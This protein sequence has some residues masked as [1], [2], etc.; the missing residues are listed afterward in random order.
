MTGKV[1]DGKAHEE[2]TR[3]G[4]RGGKAEEIGGGMD[5]ALNAPHGQRGYAGELK[6]ALPPMSCCCR[7]GGKVQCELIELDQGDGER[8]REKQRKCATALLAEI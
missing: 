1:A 7:R 2:R 3:R 8:R 5:T 6:S 4:G